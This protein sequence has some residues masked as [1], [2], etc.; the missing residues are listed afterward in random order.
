MTIYQHV[1]MLATAN[2][3]AYGAF[4]YIKN[5][6]PRVVEQ[7]YENFTEVFPSVDLDEK[8][9]LF[10]KT[11]LTPR[12]TPKFRYFLLVFSTEFVGISGLS[13]FFPLTFYV[14]LWLG[15]FLAGLMVISLLD[16]YYQL[17]PPE[18]CQWLFILGI[19]GAMCGNTSL[20]VAESVMGGIVA[21]T[22][23]YALFYIA[24]WYDG[25]E[26]L[27]RGDCW[28]M[29]AIGCVLPLEQLPLQI[30][31]A[32]ILGLSFMGVQRLRKKFH[33]IL[34]FA[35]FLSLSCSLVLISSIF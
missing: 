16:A 31:I 23:F 29:L 6:L 2:V 28:L 21:F 13:I 1:L 30:F 32:C 8:A 11:H 25:K 3:I 15:I 19:T 27:G 26:A 18:L 20:T 24:K 10:T 7:V 5:F 14:A 9:V 33:P 34:P 12:F 35:P 22:G 17:I 4:L